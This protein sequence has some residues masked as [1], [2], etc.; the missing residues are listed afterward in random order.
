M[1]NVQ[2][3]G[4]SR[5]I[6]LQRQMDVVANNIANINT[7]GFKAEAL[8]FEEYK[9]PVARNNNFSGNDQIISY[10]QDWATIHDFSAGAIVQ[11][12]NPLDVALQG[13]GFL[14]VQTG[15]SERYTRNGELKIND[16][17]LLVTN[18]GYPVLSEG[19]EIRFSSSETEITIDAEGNIYTNEGSKG[20]LKIVSFESPQ[21]LTIEGGNLYAG[22]NPQQDL[23]TKI[24]QGSLERSN[25]SGVA[26]MAEMIRVNRAYQSLAQLQKTQAELRQKAIQK[27][28]SL[29]A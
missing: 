28:G 21:D 7:T 25:V 13:N 8:L 14:T 6:A 23:N 2:I 22:I 17:G 29:Q 3:I 18:S 9:M 16:T 11:T 27:L 26:E 4:L 15:D 20:R 24:S 5:Q 10:T 1:E 19:G 12:G